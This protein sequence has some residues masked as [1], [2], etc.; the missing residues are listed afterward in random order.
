MK[1]YSPPAHVVVGT[2]TDAA[3]NSRKEHGRDVAI[4]KIEDKELPVVRLARHSADLRLGQALF[5]IGFPGVVASHALLTDA[6][7]AVRGSTSGAMRTP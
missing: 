5:V 7:G 6:G 1:F 4:L 2:T 3:G